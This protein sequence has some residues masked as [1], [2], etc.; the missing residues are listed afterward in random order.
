MKR[1]LMHPAYFEGLSEQERAYRQG[2]RGDNRHSEDEDY[3]ELGRGLVEEAY[4]GESHDSKPQPHCQPQS[5]LG[6]DD[7]T[8]YQGGIP[9]SSKRTAYRAFIGGIGVGIFLVSLMWITT[10]TKSPSGEVALPPMIAPAVE[11]VSLRSEES[12]SGLAKLESEM[13]LMKKIVSGLVETVQS[14]SRI[15]DGVPKSKE[16]PE[17]FPY[18][19]RVVTEKAHL[20]KEADRSAP[21]LLEVTKDTTLLAFA[22]TDKWL[23]VS[24]P[25]GED[26]WVSR[27]V[28]VPQKG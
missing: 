13:E 23:K 22:G 14:L 4:A 19:V 15:Q 17:I 26:A 6:M 1:I 27:G 24:T 20:R 11:P 3:R 9:G 10:G 2:I 12:P 7:S 5:N 8:A 25:R 16:I 28:V 18:P 21:S